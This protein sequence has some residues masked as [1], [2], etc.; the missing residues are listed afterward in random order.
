MNSKA[1]TKI[2]KQRTVANKPAKE[3]EWNL[4]QNKI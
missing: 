2:I 4:K 3:I 1:T